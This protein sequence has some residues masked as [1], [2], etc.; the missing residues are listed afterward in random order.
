MHSFVAVLAAA[1]MFQG[2]SAAPRPNVE[3]APRQGG[4]P[5]QQ[6]DPLWAVSG[7]W[8]P[9]QQTDPLWAV[10]GSW[11]PQVPGV[12]QQTGG[13]GVPAATSSGPADI[14]AV[15]TASSSAAAD[16]ALSESD[17]ATSSGPAES[18]SA[19]ETADPLRRLRRNDDHPSPP[20]HS[21]SSSRPTDVLTN[22]YRPPT[23]TPE[24]TMTALDE[25][26][27]QRNTSFPTVPPRDEQRSTN[28]PTV[29]ERDE[30]P[31][32]TTTQADGNVETNI[33]KAP[34]PHSTPKSD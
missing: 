16:P 8:P 34:G 15:P 22:P 5:A 17:S 2:G 1:A 26:D 9:P 6:T 27:E 7:S 24:P 32:P 25:R 21:S 33:S 31:R 4:Q 3:K 30:E 12:P 28:F 14:P 19:S 20:A 23:T 11:P 29:T 10:S 13:A 18:G